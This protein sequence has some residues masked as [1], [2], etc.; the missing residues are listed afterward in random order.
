MNRVSLYKSIGLHIATLLVFVV[1]LPSFNFH[2]LETNQVPIIVD[3]SEI[4]ISEKTNLPPKAEF[5]EKTQK[6]KA[7]KITET[8]AGNEQPAKEDNQVQ[9]KDSNNSYLES[10]KNDQKSEQIKPKKQKPLPPKPVKKPKPQPKSQPKPIE[11][12]KK[13]EIPSKP[14]PAKETKPIIAQNTNPLKSL[15]DSVDSLKAEMSQEE[16][17]ATI[18]TGTDVQNMGIDGGTDGSYF[19]Q[20]SISEIDVISSRLR[21]CWNLDPGAMGIKD[22]IIEIRAKLTQDGHLQSAEIINSSNNPRFKQVAESAKRA[23]YNCEKDFSLYTVF[24]KNYANKYESWKTIKFKFNPM[25][26]NVQ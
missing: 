19:E 22:M 18:E 16:Q 10:E 17:T 2:K 20:I 14:E 5:G 7:K 21:Q 13:E 23:V 15:M 3:L 26:G 8:Y 24:A 4:K 9:K 6:A 1:D 12:P 11:K 25:N